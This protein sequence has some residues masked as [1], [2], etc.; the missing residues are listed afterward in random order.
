MSPEALQHEQYS[1]ASD[2][3]AY[4]VVLYELLHREC[5]FEC[6]D[7]KELVRRLKEE[8]P[9]IKSTVKEGLKKLLERCLSRQSEQRPTIQQIVEYWRGEQEQKKA[10]TQEPEEVTEEE[11]VEEEETDPLETV[12]AVAA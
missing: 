5:P 12:E 4:G 1:Y 7:E 2:V 10:T 9:V 8:K 3:F 6:S 11:S